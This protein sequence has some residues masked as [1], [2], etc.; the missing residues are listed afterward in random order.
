MTTVWVTGVDY[1]MNLLDAL[2]GWVGG[3]NIV[4]LHENLYPDDKTEQE[5][6]RRTPRSSARRRSTPRSRRSANSASRSSASIVATVA[7]DSPPEGKLHAGDYHGR[8]RHPRQGPEDVADAVTKHKPGEPVDVHRRARRRAAAAE[9]AHREP[10][11]TEKSRSPRARPRTTGRRHRRHPA[12][13]RLHLPVHGR[14]PAR[15]RR[16]PQR[17]ADV[18]ARHRRQA[19]AGALT[20]GKFIAG[21]GTIDDAGQGRRDR[22]HHPEVIGARDDGRHRL[23]APADNCAEAPRTRAG[24][25][26]PGQ[27]R[28]PS[29]TPSASL[30]DI[31][32]GDTA[33]L[34]SCP[35]RLTARPP[36]ARPGRPLGSRSK[37]AA[38]ASASPGTRS[39]AG[40]HRGLASWARIRSGR[41]ARP[42]AQHGRP[43]S[44]PP[45]APGARPA[46]A[47]RR[48]LVLRHVRLGG[49]R[50]HQPLD[51]QRGARAPRPA[52]RCRP[53]SS[54]SGVLGQLALVDRGEAAGLVR[55]VAGPAGAASCGSGG[56]GRRSRPAR[57]GAAAGPS[58]PAA[59]RSMSRTAG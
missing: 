56:R 57:T 12:R 30:E 53:S 41:A 8:G 25:A 23:P 11:G 16:R 58:R 29:T 40:Q 59:C 9:K 39:G 34:P 51:G 5:S 19:D 31:R 52:R 2:Y 44:A 1:D 47:A 43:R 54:S 45:A 24:R 28:A 32:A 50:H 49:R 46:T 33:G 36:G 55:V 14:H 21:T 13:H 3:D 42:V 35:T 38:S 22:R 37:V 15:G 10:T 7:K 20:G 27:G 26:A 48:P 18:R 4:V 6:S 17:R